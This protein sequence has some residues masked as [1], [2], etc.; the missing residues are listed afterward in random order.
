MTLEHQDIIRNTRRLRNGR[1]ILSVYLETEAG[2]ALHHGHITQLMDVLR[3]LRR[4]VPDEQQQ[5]L[6][7]EMERVLAFVRG[8]Y[9]PTGRTLVVFS[10]RPRRLFQTLSLQ[11]ALRSQARFAGKPYLLP[12]DLALDDHPRIA[13]VHVGQ[14]KTRLLT[15]VLHEIE[16]E[17]RTEEHVPGRQRQGG[18]SAFRYQRDRERHIDEHF[19]AVVDD[20]SDLQKTTPFK[21][22]VLAGTD[23]ATSALTKLLP[24]RLK[25]KLAGAFNE[26]HFESS[27]TLTKRAFELAE[28]AERAEEL[29]LTTLILDRAYARAPATLGWDTTLRALAEGRVHQL[30]ISAAELGSAQADRA[31]ELGFESR[32]QIE[33]VHDEAAELLA[34]HRGIGALLRY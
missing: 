18:W 3:D 22:L 6:S 4:R 12:I 33:V 16:S 1:P 7:E 34:P 14:E 21:W 2:L 17:R 28:E 27:S 5:D 32:A 15:A 19:K 8:D 24:R 20:L 30:A 9:T 11:L 26:E 23:E 29:Q 25:A 31:V 13:I 10:S